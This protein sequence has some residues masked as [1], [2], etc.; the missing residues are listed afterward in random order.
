MKQ[1]YLARH[2]KSAW[3]TQAPNDFSRPLSKR[4]L[5]DAKRMGKKLAELEWNPQLILCSPAQRTR[6]TCDLLYQYA[7]LEGDIEW[8]EELYAASTSALVKLLADTPGSISSVMIIAHNPAIEWLL[9][10]L[11][12]DV[13]AQANGKI[14]TTTNIAKINLQDSWGNLQLGSGELVD[15]LRP[16]EI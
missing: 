10:D 3:D 1:L 2:A 4:G 12:N 9:L 6:Q 7:K 14:V 11:C 16:K 13:P 5:K 15:L 8:K